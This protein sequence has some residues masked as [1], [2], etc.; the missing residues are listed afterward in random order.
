M[1]LKVSLLCSE[2]HLLPILVG[3]ELFDTVDI[4]GRILGKLHLHARIHELLLILL[5]EHPRFIAL[6]DTA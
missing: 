3:L 4:I 1:T 6:N 2:N 5:A